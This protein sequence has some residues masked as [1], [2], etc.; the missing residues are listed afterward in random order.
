MS[1][2]ETPR[3]ISIGGSVG[4]G[5]VPRDMDR[6]DMRIDEVGRLMQRILEACRAGDEAFLASVEFLATEDDVRNRDEGFSV[7]SEVH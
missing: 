1:R 4:G 2:A 3:P 7:S 5:S 6:K